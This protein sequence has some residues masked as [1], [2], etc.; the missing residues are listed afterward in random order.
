[1]HSEQG[2][3]TIRFDPMLP[4]WLIALLGVLCLAALAPAV[5]RRA[6]GTVWRVLVFGVVLLWLAGPRLVQETHENLPDIGLLG[7]YQTASMSVG[8]RTKLTEAARTSIEGQAAKLPD[9]E[10]RTIT[11]P[12][13]G[14]AGTRLFAAIDRALADIPRGRLGGSTG[15]CTRTPGHRPRTALDDPTR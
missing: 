9:L 5:W 3:A 2:I 4:L 15:S 14:N 12:E 6:R 8:N 7:V 13:G 11:V 1:M 10:L